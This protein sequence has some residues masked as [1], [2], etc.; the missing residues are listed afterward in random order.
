[1]T[2]SL[3]RVTPA[4]LKSSTTVWAGCPPKDTNGP[5]GRLSSFRPHPAPLPGFGS[6]C[7]RLFITC[8][9]SSFRPR[10]KGYFIKRSSL[11]T[12]SKGPFFPRPPRLFVLVFISFK[13]PAQDEKILLTVCLHCSLMVALCLAL[14]LTPDRH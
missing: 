9:F 5:A 3:Q 13:P 6:A 10:H 12:V 11:T 7:P 4:V 1:M 2:A 14:N 8:S